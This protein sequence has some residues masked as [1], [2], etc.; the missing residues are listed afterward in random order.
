M[1][2]YF[3]VEVAKDFGVSEAIFIHNLAFWIKTNLANRRMV[4]D[5][6][7]WTYNSLDAFCELFP[8]WSRRQ[9]EHLTNKLETSGA[10]IKG[11]YN[12]KQYDRTIWYALTPKMYGYYPELLKYD[13]LMVLYESLSEKGAKDRTG[14]ISQNCEMDFTK[15]WNGFHK[16]V[17]PIPDNKPDNKLKI[18]SSCP[19]DTSKEKNTIKTP[20]AETTK[21]ENTK[22]HDWYEKPKSPMA[23]VSTQTTSH[24]PD[25]DFKR[26]DPQTAAHYLKNLKGI[27]L[28]RYAAEN[29][30]DVQNVE[31]S[32]QAGSG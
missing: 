20:N 2:H 28:P 17:T 23:D 30:G 8:Y 29:D 3:N 27:R 4:K 25:R 31:S 1:D 19:S 14:L 22:K 11:N 12:K 16:S 18:K 5:G 13:Y 6:L 9:I 21:S 15:L 7:C 32:K 10:I 24:Y 26:S